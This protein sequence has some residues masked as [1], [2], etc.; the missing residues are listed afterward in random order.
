MKKE[1]IFVVIVGLVLLGFDYQRPDTHSRILKAEVISLAEAPEGN[2]WRLITVKMS[3]GSEQSIR[4]LVPF[5][6]KPGYLA[7]VGVFERRIFPD[8]LDFIATPDAMP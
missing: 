6:Y 8:E 7:H 2:G 4:T 5:F 1:L 3:D